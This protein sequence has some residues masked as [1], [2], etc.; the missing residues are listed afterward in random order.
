MR[1]IF[2][3]HRQ[4]IYHTILLF[5]FELYCPVPRIKLMQQCLA[6]NHKHRIFKKML[7]NIKNKKKKLVIKNYIK[8]IK[9][10]INSFYFIIY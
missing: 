7:L 3:L 5:Q 1:P 2:I 10:Y 8:I 6:E 4:I 9:F